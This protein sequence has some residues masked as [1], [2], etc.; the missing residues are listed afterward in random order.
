MFVGCGEC[1]RRRERPAAGPCEAVPSTDGR[2]GVDGEL[3]TVEHGTFACR[4]QVFL[5]GRRRL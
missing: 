5:G 1:S 4:T 3:L 2:T